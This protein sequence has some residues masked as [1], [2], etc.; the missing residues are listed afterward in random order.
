MAVIKFTNVHLLPSQSVSGFITLTV[1][2]WL[3]LL[4]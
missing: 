3:N 1:L 2:P 4:D